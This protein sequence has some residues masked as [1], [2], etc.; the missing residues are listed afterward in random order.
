M[1][2]D[3]LRSAADPGFPYYSAK[4]S[5][6]TAWTWRKLDWGRP[7]I[8]YVDPSLK[9]YVLYSRQLN[10]RYNF[11]RFNLMNY[12]CCKLKLKII[13]RISMRMRYEIYW[14]TNTCRSCSSLELCSTSLDSIS[15]PRIKSTFVP[16]ASEMLYVEWN[17]FSRSGLYLLGQVLLTVIIGKMLY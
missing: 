15:P 14:R 6:K 12:L 9:I 3:T 17:R 2:D 1:P 10:R 5:Q 16:P 4:I 11:T 7:I 8:Y 13:L